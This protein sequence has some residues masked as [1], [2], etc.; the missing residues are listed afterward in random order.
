MTVPRTDTG[1]L[2]EQPKA[3]R[4]NPGEGNR[5]TSPVTSGEGM[6]AALGLTTPGRQA[7]VTRGA[8]LFNKNIDPR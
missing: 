5:Q 7:A 4:R 2:G 3:C 6:P 8:R 1:A